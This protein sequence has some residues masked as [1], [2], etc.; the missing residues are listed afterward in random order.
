MSLSYAMA[1]QWEGVLA[2]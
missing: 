2:K 1:S